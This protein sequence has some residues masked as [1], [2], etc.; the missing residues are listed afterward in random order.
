MGTVKMM[1]TADGAQGAPLV[2]PL[3]VAVLRGRVARPPVLR[4]LG[5]GGGLV[6]YEVTVPTGEP[7]GRAETVPVVWP[8]APP[9]AVAM[10]EGEEVV[11]VGRVRRRFFRAGGV[12]QSRTEV[13]AEQVIP[14]R[15]RARV[16][17]LV[18]SAVDRLAS[19]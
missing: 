19:T 13:V 10:A 8:S 1:A 3:N 2:R 14:A 11:V 17:R 5:T 15:Q 4:E 18:A 6:A 12:I 9:S 16:S 7:G